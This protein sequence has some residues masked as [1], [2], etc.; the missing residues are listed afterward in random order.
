MATML[1]ETLRKQYVDNLI[2]KVLIGFLDGVNFDF[3]ARVD[4][5]AHDQKEAY[6]ATVAAVYQKLKAISPN[7]QVI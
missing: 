7:Y 1:N 5:N 2:E 6:T 3:E 4:Q